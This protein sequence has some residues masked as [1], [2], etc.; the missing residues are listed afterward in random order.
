MYIQMH[1]ACITIFDISH[2]MESNIFHVLD[3]IHVWVI[4]EKQYFELPL[5]LRAM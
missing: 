2:A 1:C 5:S 4:Q 3:T